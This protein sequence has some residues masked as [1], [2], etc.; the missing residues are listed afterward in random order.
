MLLLLSVLML[1]AS[2]NGDPKKMA[3]S[4]RRQPKELKKPPLEATFRDRSKLFGPLKGRVRAL[5]SPF[6]VAGVSLKRSKIGVLYLKG[7]QA[8][9]SLKLMEFAMVTK[10]KGCTVDW[11]LHVWDN[12]RYFRGELMWGC[13]ILR[14]GKV[15]YL[16]SGSPQ[17]VVSTMIT[18]SRLHPNYFI[19]V[20][21]VPVVHRP[22][23]VTETIKN[24]VEEIVPHEYGPERFP[25]FTVATQHTMSLPSNFSLLD[26]RVKALR[27][28]LKQRL[29]AFSVNVKKRGRGTVF[30]VMEPHSLKEKFTRELFA[31]W[32]LTVL[33]TLGTNTD[34]MFWLGNWPRLGVVKINIPTHYPMVVVKKNDT[35]GPS[36]FARIS[37][38]DLNPPVEFFS[39]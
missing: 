36:L 4:R 14:V 6:D 8:L 9:N 19:S 34:K 35:T 12:D 28:I 26:E 17:K 11:I 25:N 3:A 1:L 23:M 7:E 29:N 31:E 24:F 16:L 39:Y 38:L 18:K 32:G 30:K 13:H 27:K 37:G 2:C 10:S 5:M 20:L 22:D 33:C 15:N 21:K